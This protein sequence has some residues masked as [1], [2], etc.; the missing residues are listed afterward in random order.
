MRGKAQKTT[1]Q[2]NDEDAD[3]SYLLHA[4]E[5]GY[6][7][8]EGVE[9]TYRISQ[10]AIKGAVSVQAAQKRFDLSLP[11]RGGYRASYTRDGRHLLLAGRHGHVASVEWQTGRLRCEL[12]LGKEETVRAACWL[13][14]ETIFAVAQRR[15]IY[16]YDHAGAELHRMGRH[17]EPIQM[18]Y[19]PHHFL[20]A[21]LG[22]Q[23]GTLRYEDITCGKLVG[24][25]ATA[26]PNGRA[27][28]LALNN[29]TGIIQLGH[30]RGSVTFWS[31][32]V[33]GPLV[34]MQ[35]HAGPVQAMA[36]SQDGV[37]LAT[38]GLDGTVKLWDM[39]HNFRPLH[40]YIPLRPA[41]DLAISQRGMLAVASGPHVTLWRDGLQ[42]RAKQ[43]YLS[44]LVEGESIGSLAFCPFDDV[45]GLGHSGGFSSIL[46]PGAGEPHYDSLEANP[47][48]SRKQRRE[49][50]VKQLLD[51]LPL[52]TIMLDG[53]CSIGAI[54]RDP[55]ELKAPVKE[56]GRK[57]KKLSGRKKQLLKRRENIIDE[58]KMKERERER[59]VVAGR[60]SIEEEQPRTALDRFKSKAL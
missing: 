11:G 33:N 51:K 17:Q 27:S 38:G 48:A 53:D 54:A 20:L 7:E 15:F 25:L 26:T 30:A 31:P 52:E 37:V 16:L 18:T 13:Q 43:P 2:E 1:R 55:S 24:E 3:W 39:R 4:E 45:L 57:V 47:Y 56:Q 6:L 19:L 50:E 29:A 8:A 44:H 46:V 58:N 28:S 40:R 12:E 49:A 10:E 32:A 35:C 42:H 59:I 9:R 22:G 36:V 34:T 60:P 41:S 5:T 23:D 14:N 21:S